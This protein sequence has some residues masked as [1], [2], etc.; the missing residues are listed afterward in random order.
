MFYNFIN[1]YEFWLYRCA[2]SFMI[3][4][5]KFGDLYTVKLKLLRSL[6]WLVCFP[7]FS[8]LHTST[9]IY[10]YCSASHNSPLYTADSCLFALFISPCSPEHC[11]LAFRHHFL[12]KVFLFHQ[13]PLCHA[14]A[15][16]A[17]VTVHMLLPLCSSYWNDVRYLPPACEHAFLPQLGVHV[18]VLHVEH[19]CTGNALR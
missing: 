4:D 17:P 19:P 9:S 7:F 6:L 3:R 2:F 5:I 14:P 13:Y 1:I 10:Q 16:C 15:S 8:Y 18:G 12:Q 11:S